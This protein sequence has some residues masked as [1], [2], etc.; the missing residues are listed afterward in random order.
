MVVVFAVRRVI[1]AIAVA[2]VLSAGPTDVR[3][4]AT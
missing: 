4:L 2:A 3:R 1:E